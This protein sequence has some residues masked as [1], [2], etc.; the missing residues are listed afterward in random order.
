MRGPSRVVR[1]FAS[2]LLTAPP[3]ALLAASPDQIPETYADLE[4]RVFLRTAPNGV[5][6]ATR[7]R[8]GNTFEP[9]G[10]YSTNRADYSRAGLPADQ[11][12]I[13][14]ASSDTFSGVYS[15]Q[16]NDFLLTY[17]TPTNGTYELRFTINTVPGVQTSAGPFSLTLGDNL[18]PRIQFQ[19]GGGAFVVGQNISALGVGAI[20]FNLNYQWYQNGTA[21]SGATRSSHA[22]LPMTADKAGEWQV[23]VTNELGAATSQVALIEVATVPVITQD[24]QPASGFEG[25]TATF[26]AAATGGGLNYEWQFNGRAAGHPNSPSLTLSNLTATL[27]GFYSVRVF[28]NAGSTTS[29][30]V[31]LGICTPGLDHT[32]QGRPWVKVLRTGDPVPGS[33]STFGPLNAPFTPLFTLRHQTIH[34]TARGD[35]EAASP[36]VL[37]NALVRWRDGDLET[38][39]FTNTPVPDAS[40][41]NFVFPFYPTD[42]GAG[43]MNFSHLHAMYEHRGGAIN[44]VLTESTP[45]PGRPGATVLATGSYARRDSGVVISSTMEVGTTDKPA[46]LLFH[47]GQTL[48]RLAD[49]TTD[50]PGVMIGYAY[51]LTEDSVNFDGTTIVFSTMATASGPGGVYR[52]TPGGPITKLLDTGDLLPGLTNQVVSFGDVDVEGGAVFA[53]VGSV[54]QG[55][56]QRRIVKFEPDGSVQVLAFGDFLV[57]GGPRQV[58][59]GTSGSIQRWTDGVTETVINVNALLGCRK[60]RGFFDVEAQGDDIAIGVEFADGT[61]GIYANFGAATPGLPRLLAEPQSLVVP[62]TTPATF[63]VAVSGPSP[64]TYQWFKEGTPVAGANGA[65]FTL[66]S[67]GAGDVGSY[68]AVATAGGNAITS[69]PATLTLAPPPVKPL[70]FVPPS[71]V[72]VPVGSPAALKVVAGG[73]GPLAYRWSK[74]TNLVAEG[75]FPELL[76]P[77]ASAADHGSYTVVVSNLSGVSPG[78]VATLS[79]T[80]LIT[81][82]PQPQTVPVGGTA[83]FAVAAAG[84][85]D[86]RYLWFRDTTVLTGQTNATLVIENVQAT[87]AGLYSVS[88]TGV[89]AG[90]LRSAGAALT[91]GNGGGGTAEIRLS[92]ATLVNGQLTFQVP[93][94]TGRT[95]EVQSKTALSDPGWTVVETLT[96]DGAS[97]TVAIEPGGNAAFVRVME[98]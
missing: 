18:P 64:I 24:P 91:V 11:G 51:R 7:L 80:P 17:Q 67:A 86:I 92:G 88:V 76:F 44:P 30:A 38:L 97:R 8:P 12:R 16:T 31:R 84:F 54:R 71:T 87:N 43:A 14:L 69:Q 60:I 32:W 10:G 68:H 89:G 1:F 29:A 27:A 65:V 74:G 82:Q 34:A 52:T 70:V 22:F 83:T 13:T 72:T 77:A 23:V 3:A 66:F 49:D 53:V 26:T 36:P 62:E 96:G 73:A 78:Y 95:Y 50:L 25:G 28:N 39:V 94:T 61:A 48:T 42:E 45:I 90:G 81:Q 56:V 33:P 85:D 98:R 5:E 41:Q 21:V 59:F 2:L 15:W 4:N 40:G 20:G 19:P 93:T 75:P 47:D 9:A 79:V 46:V 57:A 6:L 37:Q 63:S 35:S 55:V 58:Y